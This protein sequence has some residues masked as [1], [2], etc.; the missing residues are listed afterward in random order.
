MTQKYG[1]CKKTHPQRFHLPRKR[2]LIIFCFHQSSVIPSI[3]LPPSFITVSYRSSPRYQPHTG[4]I[5]SLLLLA[6]D[7]STLA[8]SRFSHHLFTLDA[9]QCDRSVRS[10]SQFDALLKMKLLFLQKEIIFIKKDARLK[11]RKTIRND[12]N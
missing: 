1:K 9:V 12:D 11:E 3:S 10:T 5:P 4:N 2:A 7:A 8:R 6:F